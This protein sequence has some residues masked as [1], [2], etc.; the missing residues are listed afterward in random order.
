MNAFSSLRVCL[1]AIRR[2]RLACAKGWKQAANAMDRLKSA[3]P[4]IGRSGLH[5]DDQ[6]AAG[7]DWQPA[8]SALLQQLMPAVTV[9]GAGVYRHLTGWALSSRC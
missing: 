7:V 2:V 8:M 6:P 9:A 1:V 4:A 3:R 5:H